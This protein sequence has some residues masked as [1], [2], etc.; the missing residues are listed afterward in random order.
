MTTNMIVWLGQYKQHCTG[1]DIYG[2]K[3]PVI[4]LVDNIFQLSNHE[5]F[6]EDF[7]RSHEIPDCFV[8]LFDIQYLWVIFI[9]LN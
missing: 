3:F 9:S 6:S 4:G 8:I 2:V 1:Q 5:F 7:V